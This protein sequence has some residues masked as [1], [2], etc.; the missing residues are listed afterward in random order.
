M[1]KGIIIV[2]PWNDK[3]SKPSFTVCNDCKTCKRVALSLGR[4]AI[5][6]DINWYLDWMG[7]VNHK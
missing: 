1:R 6:F 4:F 5:V 7:A 3:W 2:Y